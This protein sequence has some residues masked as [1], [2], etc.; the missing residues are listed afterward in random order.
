MKK[1]YNLGARSGYVRSVRHNDNHYVNT[2][3]HTHTHKLRLL[4]YYHPTQAEGAIEKTLVRPPVCIIPSG[5]PVHLESA[6]P[7]V[8]SDSFEILQSVFL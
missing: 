2:H 8:S 6:I 7:H 4:P 1:F 5:H 3:T